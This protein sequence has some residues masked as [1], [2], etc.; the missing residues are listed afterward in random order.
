MG[1]DLGGTALYRHEALDRCGGFN[2][3]II[4]SEEQELSVRLQACG[5]Q[6]L[7]TAQKM[8]IHNTARKESFA[9]MWRRYRSGMQSGP[10][11]VLRVALQ[12]GLFLVHARR[13]DR[14]I[15]TFVYLLLG[16]LTAGFASVGHPRLVEAWLLIGLVGFLLLGW[17]RRSLVEATFIVTDWISVA[18]GSFWT[19]VR[20]P[21]PA[22]EFVYTLERV[23]HTC[24][25]EL[26]P[27]PEHALEPS[28][29]RSRATS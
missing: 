28:T 27:D 18:I 12:D 26:E 11:Q 21:M 22:E 9:G 5:Y 13:F 7:R 19:F 24:R 6:S 2:P 23:R 10:G 1:T 17:R 25:T 14:Y 8:S 15:L 16:V 29:R 3:F 4:G 20:K